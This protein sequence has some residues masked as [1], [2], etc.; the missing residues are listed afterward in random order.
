[1]KQKLLLSIALLC[2]V[3]QGAWSQRVVDL[4]TLTENYVAQDGDALVH[5]LFEGG[6]EGAVAVVAALLGQFTGR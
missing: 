5:A 1:M 3:A 2:M 6:A 4:S